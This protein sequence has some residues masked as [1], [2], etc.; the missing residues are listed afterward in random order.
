MKKLICIIL[1][2]TLSFALI[3]CAKEEAMENQW[4]ISVPCVADPAP[5]AYV[6]SYGGK[7]VSSDTGILTLQNRND[8]GIVVHLS[9]NGQE[10]QIF[11]IQPG[12]VSVFHQAV[13]Q[14]EYTVGIHAEVKEGSEIKLMVYDGERAEVY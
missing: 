7:T 9:C 3:G 5:D 6:I 10:E 13:K 1:I 4:E 2:C 8:F 11:E 14:E 12:G